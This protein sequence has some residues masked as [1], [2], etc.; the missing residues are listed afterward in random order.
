MGHADIKTLRDLTMDY[1]EYLSK[2]LYAIQDNM[3]D[4]SGNKPDLAFCYDVVV[5]AGLVR[6]F[7][8]HER[9]TDLQERSET[10]LEK[11]MLG[12]EKPQMEVEARMKPMEPLESS[13]PLSS[14]EQQQWD[15]LISRIGNRERLTRNSYID[16]A[17]IIGGDAKIWLGQRL[18]DF[19]DPS[20]MRRAIKAIAWEE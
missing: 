8:E 20:S 17:K 12:I 18:K 7:A 1:C 16:I 2:L 13:Q 6:Q 11:V 9:L 15:G 4:G 5:R 14:L 19:H 3:A 10:T